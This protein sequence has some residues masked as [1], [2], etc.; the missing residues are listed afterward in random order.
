[1]NNSVAA[2]REW[3]ADLAHKWLDWAFAKSRRP[4]KLTS[5]FQ[6]LVRFTMDV[7][8]QMP[9]GLKMAKPMAGA[10]AEFRAEQAAKTAATLHWLRE[11]AKRAIETLTDSQEWRQPMREFMAE[12]LEADPALTM[13]VTKGKTG[14]TT[15]YY[16]N[17][18]AIGLLAIQALARHPAVLRFKRCEEKSCSTIFA[19]RKRGKYCDEHGSAA[20]RSRRHY[21][22]LDA[23]QKRE[24]RR[25]YYLNWMKTHEPRRY[26]QRHH[27]NAVNLG[28][29]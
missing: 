25:A 28:S 9:G 18:K 16:G 10:L 4:G 8:W 13:Y 24:K 6:Y 11:R 22:S 15:S 14:T 19:Q 7:G 17:L 26:R 2:T 20:S 1:L 12:L 23:D 5:D 3:R 29:S 21:R 27:P